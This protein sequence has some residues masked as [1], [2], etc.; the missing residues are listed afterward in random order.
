VADDG[1]LF[2]AAPVRAPVTVPNPAYQPSLSHAVAARDQAAARFWAHRAGCA[3]C[4]LVAADIPVG[5]EKLLDYELA[6]CLDGALDARLASRW[7]RGLRLGWFPDRD[8]APAA[9][10][11][12]GAALVQGDLLGD[13]P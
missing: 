2:D 11:G 4:S 5:R 9:A 3:R 13:T 1:A 12:G 7:E 8:P 6:L 10:G